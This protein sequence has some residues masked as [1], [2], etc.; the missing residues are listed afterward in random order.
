MAT[1]KFGR[2]TS[3]V[4][5]TSL[6][7]A[8]FNDMKPAKIVRE[9]IQN[10]LDAAVEANEDTA[11]VRFQV[12][13]INRE[14]IP[15]LRGYNN[16]FR[17]AIEYQK[18]I[19]NGKLPDAAQQVVRQIKHGLEALDTGNASLLSI[20]DNGV[21]IDDRRMNSLLGDG[22]SIKPIEYSG[23]YGVGH[24]AS[25]AL[26]DLRY[27]L[28]GGLTKEG[29]RIVCGRTA[30]ASHGVK[31]ELKLKGAEGYLIKEFGDRHN[32]YVFLDQSDH[33]AIV[34]KCL[35]EIQAEWGHGSII[36]I[37]AF[38]NFR[39]DMAL[40]DIVSKI[41]AY[42]FCTAI[43]QGK[44]T[45][46]MREDNIE[47]RLDKDTLGSVLEQDQYRTRVA[48]SGT[49]FEGLRPSGQNAYSMLKTLVENDRE[50]IAIEI[51]NIYISLMLPSLDRNP[52]VDL[53]RNGMWIT[54]RAYGLKRSN[55]A[56]CQPFHAVIE[57]ESEN[58]GN[59]HRLIR[60]AEG[61][62]HDALALELLSK[63]EQNTLKKYL[64]QI[65]DWI[66]ERT[67]T[68]ETDEYAIDDFLLVDS[69]GDEKAKRKQAR[70]HFSFWGVPSVIHNRS[71]GSGRQ[72]FRPDPPEP[73]KPRPPKPDPP[74][75]PPPEP[76]DPP[77][78]K[79]N[80]N[81][82][83]TRRSNP[84]SLHATVASVGNGKI[85]ALLECDQEMPEVRVL[86]LVD[87]NTDATCDRIWRDE[88][89]S[90]K[91]FDVRVMDDNMEAPEYQIWDDRNA[92][93][94]GMAASTR[95]EIDIE[96]KITD[97]MANLV[98]MPVLR[99]VFYRLSNPT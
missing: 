22:A 91:T 41:S 73:P 95:Y 72:E 13:K 9:L 88:D 71:L 16:A 86:L 50:R 64:E 93:I 54:D 65:A 18:D 82:D 34:T 17:K 19:S 24:L 15:D 51:G 32:L 49:S 12:T 58:G 8:S 57:I 55:F 21:G 45:I 6:S 11:I 85:K 61:P 96:C 27:L 5:F 75:T 69:N 47:K 60:K 89:V 66:K 53:F 36:A 94:L 1:L 78:P 26:S 25:M 14:D 33:P 3:N 84:V 90:I 31:E 62:M 4:G 20:M 28:Y 76:P 56:N 97:E 7:T 98:E 2:A 74:P 23:S 83:A 30:L 40:W 77:D 39:N 81:I 52:R 68:I 44:L 10:S 70:R 67:P 43:H 79:P 38:N 59:L 42:N 29:K 99:V 80:P 37:L 46:E 63:S 87:E 35:D 92:R 48:R